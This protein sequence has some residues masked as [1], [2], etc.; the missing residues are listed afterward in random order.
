[1][2]TVS[3]MYRITI[4]Y[5]RGND[6]F[7]RWEVRRSTEPGRYVPVTPNSTG[8]TV[9]KWGAKWAARRRVRCHEKDERLAGRDPYTEYI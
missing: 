7:W 5:E 9:T 1:M 6:T 4:W 8:A 2:P 3:T